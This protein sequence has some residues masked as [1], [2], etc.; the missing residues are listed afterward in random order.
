MTGLLRNL[1]LGFGV[2]AYAL[3]RR[4]S[5]RKALTTLR[6]RSGRV[7]APRRGGSGPRVL[8]HGVSVGEHV[9]LGRL[10]EAL[11]ESEVR[12]EMVVSATTTSGA[13]VARRT[14][15]SRHE[16]VRYPLDFTWMANR[17]LDA[18]RPRLVVLAELE[19]WPSF[20]AACSRRRIPVVVVNGR[21]S[22]RSWRGYRRWR[23][24]ARR[25]VRGLAQVQAQSE[26]YRDRFVE[27]G[28]PAERVLVAPSLKWDAGSAAP[29]DSEAVR[30]I[31]ALGIDR[32]RPLVVAGSTGPGEEE[33]LVEAL[34]EGCQLLLAP[35]RPE[36]WDEVARLASKM[37]RRSAA[38]GGAEPRAGARVFL[39][40]TIGELAA[41]YR[42]A[43]A[44]FVGRSLVPMG[45]SNP[46]EPIAAGVPTIVGP[47]YE[48]FAEIVDELVAAGGVE[49]SDDPM[50]VV[51]RWIQQPD[52][53]AA[54][55][56]RGRSVL[57][58]NRGASRRAA[59][60]IL[61]LLD[62][63]PSFGR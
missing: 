14:H 29:V 51:A 1:V 55:A 31:A 11:A 27:L 40:D 28:V 34:P 46:L 21:L 7:D 5:L 25:M 33:A 19:L 6:E 15:A 58:S 57:D 2:V 22:E 17:F 44:A 42:L 48:N 43:D 20:L 38:V 4:L 23:R 30:S 54:V 56:S 37:P 49:V 45:G 41:A 32:S 62:D 8:V 24:G 9:A 10:V 63:V 50:E 39:L 53:A 60:R 52:A 36:R 35:R 59:A 16:V 26:L 3:R 12:P 47:H 13:E 18:L 61:E